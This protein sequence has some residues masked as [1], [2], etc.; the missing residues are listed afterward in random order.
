MVM[1]LM[2]SNVIGIRKSQ[3]TATEPEP[4]IS[5]IVGGIATKFQRLHMCFPGLPVQW[6]CQM[7]VNSGKFC[8]IPILDT[9]KVQNTTQ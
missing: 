1:M 4:P 3:M 2:L 7:L 6:Y 5:Q 9:T 8:N